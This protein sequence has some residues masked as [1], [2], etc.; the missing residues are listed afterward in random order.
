M[1]WGSCEQEDSFAEQLLEVLDELGFLILKSMGFIHHDK[2]EW[3]VQQLFHVIT[4]N[5]IAG[6]EYVKFMEVMSFQNRALRR[7][8]RIVPLILTNDLPPP[9]TL[10]III[11][12]TVKIGPLLNSPFPMLQSR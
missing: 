4:E 5:L 11:H 3:Y 10:L 7:D 2:L 1:D 6:D 12:N 8:I 9:S